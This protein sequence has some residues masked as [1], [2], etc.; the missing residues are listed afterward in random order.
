[1]TW[2]H[3]RKKQEGK[4]DRVEEGQREGGE[5]KERNLQNKSAPHLL[6]THTHMLQVE[7]LANSNE[8]RIKVSAVSHSLYPGQHITVQYVQTWRHSQQVCDLILMWPWTGQ[9]FKLLDSTPVPLS[10]E[11]FTNFDFKHNWLNLQVNTLS[12]QG[13]ICGSSVASNISKWTCWH[14]EIHLDVITPQRLHQR[15]IL[16]SLLFAGLDR[17]SI[18][19]LFV[20]EVRGKQHH[21]HCLTT[22]VLSRIVKFPNERNNKPIGLSVQ[23]NCGE[24]VGFCFCV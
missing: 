21:L 10:S 9:L 5:G 1:M 8:Q 19:F 3:V 2:W 13:Y 4:N 20:Q 15:V 12:K 6:H 22:P 23:G 14:C 16:S 17:H 24:F 18:S 7:Q 11:V